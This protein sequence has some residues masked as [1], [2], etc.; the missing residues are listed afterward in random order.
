MAELTPEQIRLEQERLDLIQKQN[1]AAKELASTYEKMAKSKTKLTQDEK[2]LLGLTKQ[3][4]DMS[5]T[6]EKSIQKRLSGICL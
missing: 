6:I 1:Q 5:S 2:E 3:L 4:S